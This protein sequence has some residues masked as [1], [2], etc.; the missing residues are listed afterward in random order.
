[1]KRA[2]EESAQIRIDASDDLGDY[3]FHEIANE[4]QWF[5]EEGTDGRPRWES[6]PESHPLS[7]AH[8]RRPPPALP[9]PVPPLI[10][11]PLLEQ[12]TVRLA[13]LGMV[14]LTGVGLIAM[15]IGSTGAQERPSLAAAV[16]TPSGVLPVPALDERPPR[17]QGARARAKTSPNP[18]SADS[19]KTKARPVA[20]ASHHK[21][22]KHHK[23]VAKRSTR[24][25]DRFASD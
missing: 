6:L 1:M 2:S 5:V 15:G 22:A 9:P 20:R 12:R 18:K 25:T 3:A 14:G 10:K 23:Q 24:M 7:M 21:R 4:D 13:L 19:A 11:K 16:P 17:D 8:L